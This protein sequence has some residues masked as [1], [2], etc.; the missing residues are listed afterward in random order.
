ME[1]ALIKSTHLF[2]LLFYT[3]LTMCCYGKHCLFATN[4]L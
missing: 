2:T 1:E 3:H 4:C